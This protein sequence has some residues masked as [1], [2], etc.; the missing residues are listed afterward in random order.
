MSQ[1]T[2]ASS[3]PRLP[4]NHPIAH[5]ERAGSNAQPFGRN[6]EIDGANL[7]AHMAQ[8]HAAITH[9]QAAGGD[10]LV[11][12]SARIGRQQVHT[13]QTNIELI[14]HDLGQYR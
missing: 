9:R 5:L 8:R 1:A 2:S 11:G 7:C 4:G 6:G 10:G 13:L 14:G 3:A 12:A